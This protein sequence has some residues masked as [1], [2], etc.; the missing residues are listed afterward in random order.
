MEEAG[1]EVR[2][3]RQFVYAVVPLRVHAHGLVQALG[4]RPNSPACEGPWV[5]TD[6]WAFDAA[7]S[8]WA[9]QI[10]SERQAEQRTP[11]PCPWQLQESGRA[12]VQS[13]AALSEL[14]AVQA[15]VLA[16][17]GVVSGARRLLRLCLQV[18]GAAPCSLYLC[19]PVAWHSAWCLLRGVA[20]DD[21][22]AVES[23]CLS[24]CPC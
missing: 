8:F 3:G 4:E 10:V 9:A 17:V 2:R 1:V 23:S 13:A 5:S 16:G 24:L 7:F 19:A 12:L 21:V 6:S 22:R 20:T 18:G 11:M 14:V 15:N